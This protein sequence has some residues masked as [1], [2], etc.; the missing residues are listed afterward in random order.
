MKLDGSIGLVILTAICLLSCKGP[1]GRGDCEPG[2]L[3]VDGRCEPAVGMPCDGGCLSQIC[4]E[5]DDGQRFCTVNCEDHVDCPLGFFCDPARD[6]RCYP[7]QRPP[8]CQSDLDCDACSR[9][10]QGDCVPE[11]GCQI[12]AQDLDCGIC[13]R[14]QDNECVD[15][16]AC[17]P[18]VDD[19]DCPSCE[20]CD[21]LYRYCI[22]EPACLRCGGD[23]DCPVCTRCEAGECV[24]DLYIEGVHDRGCYSPCFND[25]SCPLRTSCLFDRLEVANNC[26]PVVLDFDADCSRGSDEQCASHVCVDEPDRSFCSLL[27]LEDAECPVGTDCLMGDDCRQ[28]CRLFRSEPPGDLCTHDLDCQAG[29]VCAL[30]AWQGAWRGRCRLPD[31]CALPAGEACDVLA[32]DRCANGLCSPMGSCAALCASDADCP[33][34]HICTRLWLDLPDEL[35]LAPMAVCAPFPGPVADL[36]Q[37]CS[38]GDGECVS[39]DCMGDP[40]GL[41]HSFCV[42][43]CVPG[44]AQCPDGFSCSAR[45]DEPT[46]YACQTVLVTGACSWDGDCPGSR[47]VFDANSLSLGCADSPGEGLPGAHCM[48]P[49]DCLNG[50]CLSPGRCAAPCAEA[51]HCDDGQVCDQGRA[52]YNTD[53]QVRLQACMDAPAGLGLCRRD[54]DCVEG[55]HCGPHL[56]SWN[57]GLDGQCMAPAGDGVLGEVC[58]HPLDC[59]SAWCSASGV[60]S[61]VCS[62]SEDCPDGFA[63]AR[64]QLLGSWPSALEA[65]LCLVTGKLLGEACP[66]GQVNCAQGPCLVMES[67]ESYCSLACALDEECAAVEGMICIGQGDGTGLCGWV[68]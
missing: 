26:L 23:A 57:G 14:C 41:A 35:G 47:C 53:R 18:C 32:G 51:G 62:S 13:R 8:P 39:L 46:M 61:E 48:G 37:A 3:E 49:N 54:G 7:G 65:M 17:I 28:A 58:A 56:D 60:C 27:C 15:I 2:Y 11:D 19:R 50:L 24:D 5:D 31:P 22:D 21:P 52:I 4:V 55:E 1:P 29:Q 40:A 25:G 67:G 66:D 33:L 63:C 10:R 20:R 36:G 68:P 43:D 16:V 44:E 30:E 12:C 38:G 9:C 6:S 59:V 34:Q 42:K 45:R 64:T